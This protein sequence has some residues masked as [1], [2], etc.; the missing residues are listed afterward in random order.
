MDPFH[1]F[2]AASLPP[3]VRGHD[4]FRAIEVDESVVFRE[5]V[6][7]R[8]LHDSDTADLQFS[9]PEREPLMIDLPAS[10][11]Y[12][13]GSVVKKDDSKLTDADIVSTV[14]CF[15]TSIFK[16]VDVSINNMTVSGLSQTDPGYVDYV[17]SVLNTD[18]TSA[19]SVAKTG[20]FVPDAH[21]EFEILTDE[22]GGFKKRRTR[23]ANSCTF[24]IMQ[25]IPHDLSWTSHRLIP[26]R[27][28][29]HFKFHA[30]LP[31]FYLLSANANDYKLKIETCHLN[32]AFVGLHQSILA[33]HKQLH[34]TQDM[35][36]PFTRSQ[37]LSISFAKGTHYLHW[38]SLTTGEIPSFV[39][40]GL[41]SNEGFVGNLSRHPYHF[42]HANVS[43]I[44]LMV[45]GMRFPE[46]NWKL[47][48]SSDACL[49]GY[50]HLASQLGAFERGLLIDPLKW[51]KGYT[52][53]G[54][55]TNHSAGRF[56]KAM[57]GQL[58]LDISL[59]K[60]LS[61]G[62]TIIALLFYDAALTFSKDMSPSVHLL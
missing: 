15:G 42:Q 32:V 53:F 23:I 29:L 11:M 36:I 50:Y 48:F 34:N 51:S 45:N 57:H 46:E 19:S 62:M 44:S 43:N 39:I 3:T 24:E 54:F 58:S 28:R 25:K 20:L 30:N 59:E 31:N 2:A 40:V 35:I 1:G 10:S 26:S 47:N 21:N 38:P 9:I 52:L 14:P 61:E 56:R 5:L 17:R 13:R 49:Q 37:L 6:T 55:N 33:Q 4:L 22:A 7:V 8:P 16:N 41:T 18:L 12:I 60:Q 27:C